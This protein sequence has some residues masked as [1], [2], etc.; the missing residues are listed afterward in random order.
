M[1]ASFFVCFCNLFANVCVPLRRATMLCCY[2]GFSN[3]RVFAFHPVPMM[4]FTRNVLDTLLRMQT[5]RFAE[6]SDRHKSYQNSSFTHNVHGT[7]QGDFVTLVCEIPWE[8]G[9]LVSGLREIRFTTLSKRWPRH[10]FRSCSQRTYDIS[11]FLFVS[12]S[13]VSVYALAPSPPPNR[14]KSSASL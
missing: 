2:D 1:V 7:L 6:L 3:A 9:V 14:S 10:S 12:F 11:S 4:A 8:F 5:L 13:C